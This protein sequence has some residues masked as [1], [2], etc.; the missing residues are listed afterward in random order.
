MDSFPWTLI[1]MILADA[2]C[3]CPV[4]YARL[5]VLN[6]SGNCL[7]DACASYLSTILR[8]CK[9]RNHPVSGNA[10]ISLLLK[11]ATLNRFQELNLHGIKLS[12]PVVDSLCQL[13]KQCCLSG[14]LLG[15]T[16]IGTE[17][18][19]QLIKPLSKD[20]QELV[21]L[22]LSFCGLTSDYIVGLRDE[23]SLISGILELN[24]GGNPIMKEGCSELASL[25][26]NPQCCL[27][28][29]VVS[30]CELGL[31]G[32][33]CMLQALSQNCSVEELILADNISPDEIQA[34]T[35][36]SGLMEQNS[37][38]LQRD[39]NQPTSSLHMLAP[40]GVETLPHE[41]C[42]VNTNE[43]Q[44]EV[45]DSEDDDQGVEVTLSATVG[46]QIRTP[47]NRICLSECQSMQELIA[48]IKMAGNLKNVG[49]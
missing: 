48:S 21:R 43:N 1:F 9:G 23:A 27:R 28:V 3:E 17:C 40:D 5:E 45:A 7:T 22:D 14:L 26:R 8:T 37:N 31:V 15:N 42:G 32:L 4:L 10:I 20:T 41:M 46:N 11:L 39:I 12:K 30:K 16:N 35:S 34:L 18:A 36:N 33:I 29:L 49:S 13:A 19:I 24:L 25:L 2:I 47:P 44:L 6:I 38:S